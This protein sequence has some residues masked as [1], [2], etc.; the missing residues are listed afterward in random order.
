MYP[1]SLRTLIRWFLMLEI[2]AVELYRTHGR[3]VPTHLRPLFREFESIE[4]DH[5]E[6]F[7]RLYRTLNNGKNWWA[8]PFVKLGAKCLALV[9]SIGGT[10]AIL[11]FE[12]NIER[13]AV[14][15]Y[16]DALITVKDAAAR[17][18][19]A[20]VLAD[21]IRHDELLSLLRE[22]RGDEERHIQ[23]LDKIIQ[24]LPE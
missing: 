8:I 11:V 24:N 20:R 5:R 17:T 3:L 7:S 13:K 15:D 6:Q 19:I 2:G 21:E 22:Y 18:A 16:T 23:E 12:R 4:I 10:R 9:V 14:A 1:T